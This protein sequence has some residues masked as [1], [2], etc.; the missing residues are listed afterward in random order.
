MNSNKFYDVVIIGASAEGITTAEKLSATTSKNIALV[1]KNFNNV[2]KRDNIEKVE[3]IVG[4]V[5]FSSYNHGLIGLTLK[6][7]SMVFCKDVVIATGSKPAKMQLKNSGIYYKLSDIEKTSKLRQAIVV[8]GDEYAVTTAIAASK[9]FK[10]IYLCNSK[11]SLDCDDKH[12]EKLNN[13]A[14][15][16]YLPSCNVIGCKN[17]KDG[18]LVEVKL[19]T[20][21]TIRCSAIVACVGRTPE[22]CGFSKKMID[23]DPDGL[24]NNDSHGR[25]LIPGVYAIGE[26]AKHNSKQTLNRVV[27]TIATRQ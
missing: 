2:T 26:C 6:D 5:V 10:Y 14:N 24:L 22:V 3:K 21:D 11:F 7:R 25:M 9:K 17:D 8:G 27:E 13:V 19:D 16:V 20:Y 1:S 18:N 4:E 23:I 12:K 15:I